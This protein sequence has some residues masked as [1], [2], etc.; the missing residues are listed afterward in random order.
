MLLSRVS[1][2]ASAGTTDFL[3][4]FSS[5]QVI[6]LAMLIDKNDFLWIFFLYSLISTIHCQITREY[7]QILANKLDHI[8]VKY[9]PP[10]VHNDQCYLTILY[11]CLSFHQRRISVNI[12]I[13]QTLYR[14]N[15]TVFR[16]H[17]FC[18]KSTRVQIRYV[19]IRLPRSLAYQPDGMSNFPSLPIEQGRLKV[20]MYRDKHENTNAII[21]QLEYNVRFLPVYKRPKFHSFPWNPKMVETNK[22]I[23]SKEPGEVF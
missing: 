23:C 9:I 8:T 7:D 2:M 4:L 13:D 12:Q 19:Q 10:F 20:T 3:L 21:N 17:W 14:T 5:L 6:H 16:R 22:A 18:Q 11:K 1:N 15:F